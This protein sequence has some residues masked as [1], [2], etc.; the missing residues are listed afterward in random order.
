MS[1]FTEYLKNNKTI[2]EEIEEEP[3]DVID[4]AADFLNKINN[5]KEINLAIKNL[6]KLIKT[7]YNELLKSP[8]FKDNKGNIINMV[9]NLL[10]DQEAQYNSIIDNAILN[11][12]K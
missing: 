12:F 9:D 1:K 5:N 10:S 8:N 6:N 4:T 2:N 11:N 3:E 7:K